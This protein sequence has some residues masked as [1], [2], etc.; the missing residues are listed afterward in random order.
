M[1]PG[2]VGGA[3]PLG[4]KDVR[5]QPLFALQTPQ[6]AYLVALHR[7]DMA[8]GGLLDWCGAAFYCASHIDC[9]KNDSGCP[10]NSNCVF[11]Q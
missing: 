7:V 6:H 9:P 11:V 4:H 10:N 2:T 3:L 8:C 5:G 1:G